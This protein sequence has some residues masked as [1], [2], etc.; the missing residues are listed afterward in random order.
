MGPRN[1]DR[2]RG[3][4]SDRCQAEASVF[5]GLSGEENLNTIVYDTSRPVRLETYNDVSARC[6]VAR[7]YKIT[8]SAGAP[9]IVDGRLWGVMGIYATRDQ[10]IAAGTEARLPFTELLATA[11]ANAES[12]AELTRSTGADRR[13]G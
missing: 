7:K 13:R 6:S 8:S 9:I 12:R 10:P 3:R 4:W 1:R 11:I 2:P 5:G